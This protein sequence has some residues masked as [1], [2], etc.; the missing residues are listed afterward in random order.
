MRQ[1]PAALL[2]HKPEVSTF[3][4][5]MVTNSIPEAHE[6]RL[7]KKQENQWGCQAI[8]RDSLSRADLIGTVAQRVT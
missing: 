5:W 2:L 1:R 3:A 4:V 8:N 6:L 7:K